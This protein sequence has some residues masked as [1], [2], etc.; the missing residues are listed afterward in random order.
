[1]TPARARLAVLIDAENVA[2]RYLEPLLTE[3]TKHG[4]ATIK[5]AYGDWT[6][7]SLSPWRQKLLSNSVIPVQQFSYTSGKNSSD[8]TLIID[9]MD[10]LHAGRIDGF[11]LVSSDSDF[12]RLAARIREQGLLAHGFGQL[13]TPKAFVSACDH[14]HY[15][16]KLPGSTIAAVATAKV[17]APTAKV[18]NSAPATNKPPK[19]T[20]A[21]AGKPLAP[22]AVA[23]GQ[24]LNELLERAVQ[25]TADQHG[26]SNMSAVGKR[27]AELSPGFKASTWGFARL[28]ALLDA[29]PQFQVKDGNSFVR[30]NPQL[31]RRAVRPALSVV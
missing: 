29:H 12:T 25:E 16:E 17:Q 6:A 24:R 21:A 27:L 13:K 2:A 11:C 15:L 4:V 31:A 7:P 14:F 9:A 1:M 8:S 10:L 22:A 23:D 3:I 20:P 30:H 26:W 5:R 28:S 18:A 19:A